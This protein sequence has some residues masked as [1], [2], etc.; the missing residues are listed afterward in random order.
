MKVL[1]IFVALLCA[2]LMYKMERKNHQ[3]KSFFEEVGNKKQEF[4]K[5]DA[6]PF[7]RMSQADLTP[8][9]VMRKSREMMQYHPIFREMSPALGKRVL[10]TFCDQLDPLKMYFTLP[11]VKTWIDPSPEMVKKVMDTF[12]CGNLELFEDMLKTMQKAIVR[13]RK[14]NEKIEKEN[15]SKLVPIKW[16]ELPFAENEKKLYQRLQAVRAFQMEAISKL[17]PKLIQM[18]LLRIQKRKLLFEQV[19]EERD[20]DIFKKTVATF[21]MKAFAEAL[22]SESTFFTPF[23]A[24]Q[25][26]I[27][28][29]QRLFGIGVLLRDD[30]DGF[31]VIKVIEGGPAS[32]QGGL[33]LED[34]I[35]A[36]NGEPVIGLDLVDVVE[37]IRGQP[38]SSIMLKIIRKDSKETLFTREVELKRGEVV[39]QDLRYGARLEP[40]QDGVIACVRLHSFYQDEETSSYTDVF[41]VLEKLKEKFV[42]KGVILDLRNNPGGLLSQA[43]AVSGLFIDKGIVVSIHDEQN[44]LCHMRNTTQKKAWDGPLVVLMNRASASASEIVAQ[45]LQDWGRAIIVGDDRSF[46]KGS[47][48]LF[49]LTPDGV[50]VPNPQGE[51]KVTRGRYYTVSGKSPQLVGVP[52]D[53]VVPG[54]FAFKDIGEQYLRFPLPADKIAPHF[55]DRF[56]D[57]PLFHKKLL[58]KLYDSAMEVKSNKW[59]RFLPEIKKKAQDRLEKNE[60]FKRFIEKMKGDKNHICLDENSSEVDFQLEE[61]WNVIKDLVMA[62]TSLFERSL[63]K[64]MRVSTQKEAPKE[65]KAV[66]ARAA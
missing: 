9:G 31:S 37:L 66:S 47:F 54:I 24:K 58:Q 53:I 23:E 10:L 48:Q 61:A 30:I 44:K 60:A 38:G 18:A 39:V 64:K 65:E 1:I 27:N 51:F 5:K 29:Q 3:E 49:T 20:P 36:V 33:L 26:L 28:M 22:D 13:N 19:R 7:L 21:I 4:L 45:A 34:K 59:R 17:D 55:E 2:P 46:G 35:I 41:S 6:L 62:E 50:T 16:R 15:V 12:T 57:V 42:V 8:E 43:I 63:L 52:S 25:L 56:E 11:E 32:I 14:M 40:F